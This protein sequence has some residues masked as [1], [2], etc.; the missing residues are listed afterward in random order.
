[1]TVDLWICGYTLSEYKQGS[2]KT[3]AVRCI[4]LAYHWAIQYVLRFISRYF[5]AEWQDMIYS[6]SRYFF[7]D[8]MTNRQLQVR[9]KSQYHTD[10]FINR[11][12][13]MC[14]KKWLR[15][16]LVASSFPP[17]CVVLHFVTACMT[18]EWRGGAGCVRRGVR[19]GAVVLQIDRERSNRQIGGVIIFNTTYPTIPSLG[20]VHALNEITPIFSCSKNRQSI[21]STLIWSHSWVLH[22]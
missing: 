2:L 18:W 16:T 21:F 1:M 14:M 20:T 17:V 10:T 12:L 5:L 9:A 19:Q 13:Y 22:K 7:L 6:I 3:M 8:M 15:N 4:S 11:Q